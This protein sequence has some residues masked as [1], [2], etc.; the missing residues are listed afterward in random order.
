MNVLN[1][2]RNANG[3][4]EIKMEDIKNSIRI[5]PM[6]QD[7]SKLVFYFEKD[8]TRFY[9]KANSKYTYDQN[10]VL[11]SILLTENGV[12]T[13][14]PEFCS[15]LVNGKRMDGIVSRDVVEDRNH[16][17]IINYE[18][19]YDLYHNI[20]FCVDYIFRRIGFYCED[21]NL[22]MDKAM[23]DDLSVLSLVY[24]LTGQQ[25]F[26]HRN[27]EFQIK[28][29]EQGEKVISLL[30]FIDKSICFFA[31]IDET[32]SFNKIPFEKIKA[33]PKKY[34][35]S[36][37]Y[38]FMFETEEYDLNKHSRV[39]RELASKITKNKKLGSIFRS[40]SNFDFKNAIKNYAK[41]NP[42]FKFNKETVEKAVLMFE[43]NLEDLKIMVK[44]FD[45][46]F[47]VSQNEITHE[48]IE[49]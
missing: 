21:N 19:I 7:K 3:R 23:Y 36:L 12:K 18:H 1:Q 14:E 10:E 37:D 33:D 43:N 35:Q 24:Y 2:K 20:D 22:K 17:E 39:V 4:I 46:H 16:V 32:N 9:F 47:F 34:T 45:N 26:T 41:S 27:L 29:N 25:D 5:S 38:G 30:P 13:N 11:A 28:Q 42:N 49:F 44:R 6:K 48:T 40:F 8:N 15:F 31:V